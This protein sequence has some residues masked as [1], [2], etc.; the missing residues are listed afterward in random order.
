MRNHYVRLKQSGRIEV[1]EKPDYR[2]CPKHKNSEILFNFSKFKSAF[3]IIKTPLKYGLMT[4]G[5]VFMYPF[6]APTLAAGFIS[7]APVIVLSEILYDYTSR[8][9]DKDKATAKMELDENKKILLEEANRKQYSLLKYARIFGMVISAPFAA[10]CAFFLSPLQGS[11]AAAATG[12]ILA[13]STQAILTSFILR[14]KYGELETS[15]EDAPLTA[16]LHKTADST[17]ETIVLPLKKKILYPINKFIFRRTKLNKNYSDLN[18]AEPYPYKSAEALDSVSDIHQTLST[19]E[20]YRQA[21]DI[22]S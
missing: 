6:I 18:S 22:D 7:A 17:K 14:L 16:V 2:E 8:K 4:A 9:L 15:Q 21:A 19:E 12:T 5:F 3:K 13:S 1:C 10:S 20:Y 11:L